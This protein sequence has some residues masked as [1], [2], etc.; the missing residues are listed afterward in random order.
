MPL[1]KVVSEGIIN[2]NSAETWELIELIVAIR[3]LHE[4]DLT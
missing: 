4:S 2:P 3:E 1:F